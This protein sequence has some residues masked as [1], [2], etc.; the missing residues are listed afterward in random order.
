[1]KY[2]YHSIRFEAVLFAV[3]ITMMN[4]NSVKRTF[5]ADKVTM[6][7]I[8][9]SKW[10]IKSLVAG[11]RVGHSDRALNPYTA[12]AEYIWFSLNYYHIQY[13]LVSMAKP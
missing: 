12:G 8:Y 7:T 11:G 4:N 1:M 3:K 2:R 10:D 5:Q 13:R 6:K 9:T